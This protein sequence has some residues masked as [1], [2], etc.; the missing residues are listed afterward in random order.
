MGEKAVLFVNMEE[1]K[2]AG[3]GR[4]ILFTEHLVSSARRREGWRDLSEVC[5]HAILVLLLLTLAG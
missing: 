2:T 1:R 4:G 5:Q 3:A